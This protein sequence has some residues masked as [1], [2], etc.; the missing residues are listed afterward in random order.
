MYYLK[1]SVGLLVII[2]FD[3]YKWYWPIVLFYCYINYISVYSHTN[4]KVSFL[5]CYLKQ[6]RC[7]F[8]LW[9]VKSDT[10]PL[11]KNYEELPS[12][13]SGNESDWEPD[14]GLIPGPAQLVKDPELP[15]A[16]VCRSQTGLGSGIIVALA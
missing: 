3:I 5:F 11:R 1:Y 15:Q 8:T 2:F 4:W 14:P 6:F 13:H 12:W 9:S 7:H 10:I 16:V